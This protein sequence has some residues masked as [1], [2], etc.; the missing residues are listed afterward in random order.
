MK[1]V[2]ALID[3]D[4]L[5][6]Y[7]SKDTIEESIESLKFR[8]SNILT[9]TKATK[10]IMFLTGGRDGFRYK[11]Y[12]EYK[13]NRKK[14]KYGKP[15]KYLKTLKALM[16]EEYN[17]CLIPELEADDLV[18]YYRDTLKDENTETIICSPDKDVLHQL[19]GKHWDYRT[20]VLNKNT[21]DE[22]V[23]FG[24]WVDTTQEMGDRF[25]AYQL[26]VGDSTD[27]IPGIKVRTDYMR[28]EYGLD[29]R[30]GIG[31][32][33]A[34]KILDIIDNAGGDYPGHI[35]KCYCSKY[36]DIKDEEVRDKGW[37]DYQLNRQLL[38][39]STTI[40]SFNK[41]LKNYDI[42]EHV[43]DVKITEEISNTEDF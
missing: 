31:D 41:I 17:S 16:I 40:N 18:A 30:Q 25:L 42:S 10:C 19:A 28:K 14:R 7:S 34:N 20:T 43:K 36:G 32:V 15:L 33:T 22:T 27:D 12:P 35:W 6:F 5:V 1:E 3:A 11:L 37:K 13:A 23:I 9:E 24:R 4:S 39:L 26:L 29:K 38:Q 2:I 21:P 8:I